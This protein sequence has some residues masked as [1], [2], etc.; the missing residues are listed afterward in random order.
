MKKL[1][2]LILTAAML[3]TFSACDIVNA[4]LDSDSVV[5]S[6]ANPSDADSTSDTSNENPLEAL[7]E[8]DY[9]TL[10]RD[11]YEKYYIAS[12]SPKESLPN[13]S[14]NLLVRSLE[15]AVSDDT[16]G[17][18]RILLEKFSV[19]QSLFERIKLTDEILN[20][21]CETDKITETNEFFS[22]KKLAVLE[23]FWGTGDKFPQ[24]TSEIT[25]AP[26][27]E[28]YTFLVQRY[29]MAMIGSQILDYID[30]IG[31]T[32][33][34]DGKYYPD[35]ENYNKRIANDF[36]SGVLSE[37]QLSDNVLYLVYYGVLKDKSLAMLDDFSEYASENFPEAVSLIEQSVKEIAELFS[38]VNGVVISA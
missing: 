33:G 15:T 19:E 10:V 16:F 24:P 9:V 34:S 5:Q 6:G 3:L 29:C 31:S 7:S 28:A 20:A 36:K 23:G 38:G 18:F 22:P 17:S 37:K 11:N 26:L 21:L 14:S 32:L 13:V 8:W 35:M 12:S 27:E 2:S 1:S 30:L 25:V 4:D